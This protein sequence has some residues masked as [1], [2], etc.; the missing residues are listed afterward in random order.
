MS[1]KPNIKTVNIINESRLRQITAV[2]LFVFA[3]LLFL[4][5]IS[6]TTKDQ[7]NIQV[8]FKEMLGLF[9]NE[10]IIS[11]K[12]DTTQNWLGLL[13]AIISNLIIN[14]TIGYSSVVIPILLCF[15]SINI[16][17]NSDYQR[18]LRM[19]A[20]VLLSATLVATLLG[21]FQFISWLPKPGWEWYGAIGSFVASVLSALL[22]SVGALLSLATITIIFLIYAVNF[23][24]SHFL[25]RSKEVA[26][27]LGE[28]AKESTSQI[29]AKIN[30]NESKSSVHK[31]Q[32]S[33]TDNLKNKANEIIIENKVDEPA[34]LLRKIKN[35]N[36]IKQSD[37]KQNDIKQ[38]E[39]NDEPI[40]YEP[41]IERPLHA[42]Q[43]EEANSLENI[44]QKND[45]SAQHKN[46]EVRQKTELKSLALSIQ[47]ERERQ[48]L[49][50]ETEENFF[51]LEDEV[52]DYSPPSIELLTAQ[53]EQTIIE[54]DE[55][56][57]NARLLQEKLETFKIKIE[58]LKITPG[59]VVT[60][61]EFV[62]A[63]GI[64]IS[65]IESLQDDIALAMKARGI[66]L[67]APMP[68]KGTVGIEIPNHVRETVRIRSV[69]NTDRFR[70][71]DMQLPLAFGKNTTGEVMCDDLAKMPHLLIAGATGS[72]K[73]VGVN[74]MVAS[75]LYRMHPSD[76]KFVIIDPKKVELTQYK[77]LAQHFLAHCPDVDEDIITTPANA[78]LVLK[79]LVMEMD[80]RYTILGEA[81][82]RN[83][84][85]YNKKIDSGTLRVNSGKTFKKIP[86]IVLIID[87][88]A[89]LM[90]SA[91][92]EVEEPIVRLAQMSRA[93][94]IHLLVATQ[95][96]SVDVI[97]G[98]I[99]ANFPARIAYQVASRIDSR[100][101]LDTA[102]AEQLIGN[103]DMLYLSNAYPKPIR[104]QNAYISTEEI[105]DIC[106]A[107]GDQKGYSRPY[108]LPSIIEKEEQNKFGEMGDKDNLFDE[109]ARLVVMHQQAS[110]SFLQRKMKLG[111][112]RAA[113]IM[114]QLQFAGIVGPITGSGAKGR[115]VLLESEAEL[116][117]YL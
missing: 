75:L 54:D 117:A 115:P 52:I 7:S 63:A 37:I 108:L 57:L 111:Y 81:G 11:A 79:S 29:R 4:S 66:R 10:P 114:D 98:I 8:T 109:A 22:G 110:T 92:K 88:F 39:L 116:E 89:D 16:F 86:Y 48:D 34:L 58:K 68:G 36:D 3:V 47:H 95:R 76:L 61:Y 50:S 26:I 41:T 24:I 100:T 13:G 101:I 44:T 42:K 87:E 69:I 102:G 112:G 62:P 90:I 51:E 20:F 59:P 6:Y 96:P 25:T 103:G 70:S 32:N 38:K 46:P 27:N 99:K 72:G 80:R 15:W 82:Q 55:L 83:I 31:Q 60:L 84:S 21:S 64:K 91:K 106:N 94:G 105:E 67:I 1:R 43:N 113:K 53:T 14:L 56:K 35:A 23:N 17:N 71:A 45:G 12:A 78:V 33:T 97:T 104:M 77:A 65:Q 74:N 18:I 28:K 93:T 19:S 5:L 30:P 107:I 2:C 85:D 73:S 49:E 40:Y 9:R